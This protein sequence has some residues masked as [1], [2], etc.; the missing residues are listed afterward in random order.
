MH[1][2]SEGYNG[3]SGVLRHCR[4]DY[5]NKYNENKNALPMKRMRGK[6]GADKF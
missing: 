5:R 2:L 1:S 6:V 4:K 3:R